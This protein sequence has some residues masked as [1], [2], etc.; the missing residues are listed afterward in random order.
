[1]AADILSNFFETTRG[2][3]IVLIRQAG[4]ATAEEIAAAIGL[5]TN[6]VRVRLTALERD[7]LV[8]RS[9]QRNGRTRPAQLY[10]V[11][12][13]LEQLLSRAYIPL[14]SQLIGLL[15]ERVPQE[16]IA[17]LMRES[18]RRLAAALSSKPIPSGPL[19]A[20]VRA[21]SALLNQEIGAVT[22]VEPQANGAFILRGRGC[23]LAALTGA[24]THVCLVVEALIDAASGADVHE[25]CEVS[26]ERPGCCFEIR[27]R[28]L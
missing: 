6:A 2:R 9:G 19:E 1:M 22:A 23:P 16:Q 11:S 7:G 8:R 27:E 28:S 20:R 21:V 5:T 3:V 18:G 13:E 14:S 25:R 4:R 24:H 26:A 12:R 15:N 10:E 17:E